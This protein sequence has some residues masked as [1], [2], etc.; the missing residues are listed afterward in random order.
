MYIAHFS[1]FHNKSPDGTP[2]IINNWNTGV[3][4]VWK[5]TGDIL[6]QTFVLGYTT[7]YKCKGWQSTGS[8][9]NNHSTSK[10]MI[11]VS[12]FIPPIL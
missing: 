10:W 1:V 5:Y 2:C 8:Q 7:C 3:S 11:F 9:N 6:S 12:L 4:I